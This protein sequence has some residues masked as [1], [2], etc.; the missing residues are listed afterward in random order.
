MPIGA[1]I[2]DRTVYGYVECLPAVH[3]IHLEPVIVARQV[4]P[5]IRMLVSAV[6]TNNFT[7]MICV[8]F[9]L[10]DFVHTNFMSD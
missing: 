6:R 5:T 4:L 2:V 9:R 10:E 7:F 1:P 8:V 3:A